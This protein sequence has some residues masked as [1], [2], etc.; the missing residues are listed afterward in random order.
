MTLTVRVWCEK[1][2][3]GSHKA[4]VVLVGTLDTK[5]VEYA[6]LRERIREHGVAVVPGS[7]F[8]SP[9]HFRISFG[10]ATGP[11]QTGLSAIEE[12]LTA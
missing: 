8:D 7:F 1:T 4:T 11:L 3:M 12:C 2:G 6:Y 5:G 10:G 9:S